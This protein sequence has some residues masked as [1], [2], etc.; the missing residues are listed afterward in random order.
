M[1][2][3]APRPPGEPPLRRV[4]VLRALHLGD[5]L[6][7]VPA[8]R[9]LRAGLPETEIVLVGLPWA[10]EF[11]SRFAAYLDGFLALPGVPGLPEQPPEPERLA[12]FLRRARRRRFDLAVQLHG[13]GRVTNGL[14]A[15]LGA[16]LLAG[17]HPRG[18][19]CPDP[20]RFLPYP[21]A[22]PEIRRLL[23]LTAFLGLPDRGEEL[24]F[25]LREEDV[26]DLRR[27]PEAAS[28]RPGEY[29]CVHPGGRD[30]ARRWAPEE[31]AAVADGLG[32]RGL[33]VVLTGTAG[34]AALTG[35]VAGR[36]AAGPPVDLT[37]RTSLG[38]LAALLSGA[39]LLVCNDTGVSHL[40]AALRLPSVVVFT[41]SDP[42]RWAPLD[43]SRHRA[44]WRPAAGAVLAEAE[45]LLTREGNHAA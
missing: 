1:T 42:E 29:V 31:F 45:R 43:R 9:S 6:C 15:R 35:A 28:L 24:E 18:G 25:P 19:P 26:M 20:S 3:T 41:G 37:G 4:A 36:M 32:R 10:R 21:D 40:A 38:A 16:R 27:L 7:A 34:E 17:F 12:A 39:R 11:A 13:D 23:R 8:L 14:A 5:L 30:P 22:G 2:V 44:L 33:R